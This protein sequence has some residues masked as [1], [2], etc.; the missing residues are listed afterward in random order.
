M[1]PTFLSTILESIALDRRIVDKNVG[2]IFSCDKAKT[3]GLIKPLYNSFSHFLPP[4]TYK[5]KFQNDRNKKSHKAKSLCGLI[6][7][8]NF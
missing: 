6:N 4:Y 3:F 7:D 2:A 5:L 8:K 1:A